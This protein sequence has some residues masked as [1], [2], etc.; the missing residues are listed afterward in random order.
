MPSRV[1]TLG[2]PVYKNENNVKNDT[3][4]Y[5]LN[6][7]LFIGRSYRSFY[8]SDWETNLTNLPDLLKH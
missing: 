1:A 7:V 8:I 2:K 3:S 5:H 6:M 4:I